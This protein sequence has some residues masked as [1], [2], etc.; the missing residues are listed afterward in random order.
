MTVSQQIAENLFKPKQ[1]GTHPGNKLKLDEQLTSSSKKVLLQKLQFVD[2]KK[3][4]NNGINELKSKYIVLN[5]STGGKSS[6]ASNGQISASNGKG[7]SDGI[8]PPK[9]VLF[10]PTV[11]DLQWKKVS[12]AGAG[13]TNLGNTCFMNSALQCLSYTPPLCNYLLYGD[14]RSQCKM[15]GQFC[16]LCALEQH[17]RASFANSGRSI[18]PLSIIKNLR[19]IAKHMHYGR[20]EDAHEFIRYSI[21]AMQRACLQGYS[22]K[23]DIH[24]KATTLVYQIFGG[25]LRSRVK[26]RQCKAV[27]DTFD[28]Y[29]DISLDINKQGCGDLRRCFEHFVKPE[30][31]H[32]DNCYKCHRC[33]NNVQAS[34]KFSIHRSSNILTIQ[35]KRFSSFMGNKINCDISYPMKL[36]ISPYMSNASDDGTWYELYAVLVHSGFS[37]QSGHYYAYAKASN[38]Q[39]YCFNDASVYQVNV[40]QVLNQQAYLLFYH[41]SHSTNKLVSRQSIL[42]A[43]REPILDVLSKE[44]KSNQKSSSFLSKPNGLTTIRD[45]YRSTSPIERTDYDRSCK[46]STVSANGNKPVT[47]GMEGLGKSPN[48]QPKSAFISGAI[49]TST[50]PETGLAGTSFS[51]KPATAWLSAVAS[52]KTKKDKDLKKPKHVDGFQSSTPDALK[53]SHTLNGLSSESKPDKKQPFP[54]TNSVHFNTSDDLHKLKSTKTES[55]QLS[56]RTMT[57]DDWFEAKIRQ[58]R[59]SDENSVSKRS[60]KNSKTRVSFQLKPFSALPHHQKHWQQ[61]HAKVRAD[62]SKH[63]NSGKY[64]RSGDDHS[65]SSNESQR[66]EKM[67]ESRNLKLML[68]GKRKMSDEKVNGLSISPDSKSKEIRKGKSLS[69]K[70]V[71]CG[72]MPSKKKK[73]E[74][75]SKSKERAGIL[76]KLLQQSSSKAYGSEVKAWD[77]QQ[78]LVEEEA[79]KDYANKKLSFTDAWDREY[80]RG[81]PKKLKNMKKKRQIT[82]NTNLFQKFQH[83]RF[84]KRSTS[85]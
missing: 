76:C 72:P 48:A 12:R 60:G 19:F 54:S 14:H 15:K 28:P 6:F 84:D 58:R 61:L 69:S 52:N 25:Y 39:W 75:Q 40:N 44:M 7:R 3:P 2:A 38:G 53:P 83:I 81:K 32:G 59:D 34:K 26:C 31:L 55:K 67:L 80:D 73:L 71:T 45:V 11:L 35:L 13:L 8:S 85:F 82:G 23:L 63:G 21:D 20:Q 5:P 16:M 57:T 62:N 50:K 65:S 56:E 4:Y 41:K 1:K 29:L 33:K 22:N 64:S 51:S 10:S 9:Y 30:I 68:L 78:S 79:K 27:S 46:S 18:K 37:C 74:V 66:S 24:T 70:M 36:N 47:T 77:G 17:L 49:H 42:G 43:Q